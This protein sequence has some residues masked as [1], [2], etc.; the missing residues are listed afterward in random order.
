MKVWVVHNYWDYADQVDSLW[1][2]EWKAKQ[3]VVTMNRQWVKVE[4]KRW[5]Q[6]GYKIDHDALTGIKADVERSITYTEVEM[7]QAGGRDD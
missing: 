1:D 3:R 4:K 7:N 5:R 2:S 6:L